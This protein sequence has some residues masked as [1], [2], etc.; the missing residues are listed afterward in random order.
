M[1]AD[2]CSTM[3]CRC[4]DSLSPVKQEDLEI[5]VK[6]EPDDV[7]CYINIFYVVKVRQQCISHLIF[8]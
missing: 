6:D 8:I 7:C 3:E 1:Y 2:S 4:G 5:F